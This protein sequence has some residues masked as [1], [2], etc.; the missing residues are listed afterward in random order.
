MNLVNRDKSWGSL[1]VLEHIPF[2]DERMTP[3]SPFKFG[4][5][6]KYRDERLGQPGPRP[7]RLRPIS[8]V[9]W[10]ISGGQSFGYH[11]GMTDDRVFTQSAPDLRANVCGCREY[12]ITTGMI[13]GVVLLSPPP[14]K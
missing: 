2:W 8:G 11:Y 10:S 4:V 9:S 3:R 1:C 6:G 12:P 13:M 5:C 14:M 7:W